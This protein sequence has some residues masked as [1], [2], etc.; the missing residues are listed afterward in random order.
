MDADY[1]YELDK[2]C[3][4]ACASILE[5]Q[6]NYA[7]GDSFTIPGSTKLISFLSL[8]GFGNALVVCS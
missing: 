5:M 6:A 8:Y 3:Q 2:T 1:M 4:T 7:V